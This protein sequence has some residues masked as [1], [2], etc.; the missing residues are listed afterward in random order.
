MWNGITA[1]AF[2]KVCLG[3]ILNEIP[4]PNVFHLLPADFMSKYELLKEFQKHFNTSYNIVTTA[5]P[6]SVNRVLSSLHD[7]EPLWKAAGYNTIPSIG[8][9]VSEL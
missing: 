5:A 9:L 1:K 8:Q 4:M 2:S 7:S 3:I 6:V